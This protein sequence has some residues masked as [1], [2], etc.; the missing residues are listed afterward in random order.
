MCNKYTFLLKYKLISN[1]FFNRHILAVLHFNAN[2]R[3]EVE[4]KEGTNKQRQKVVFPKFK[5]GEATIRDVRIR[6]NFGNF[7][8]YCLK[9]KINMI[10]NRFI[11]E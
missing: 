8:I 3:R 9:F 1:F 7:N 2:L 10:K 5:N 11:F 6:P 4:M